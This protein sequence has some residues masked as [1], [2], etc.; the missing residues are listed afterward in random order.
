LELGVDA[1]VPKPF[2]MDELLGVIHGLQK[3]S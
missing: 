1:Y 3:A 2:D